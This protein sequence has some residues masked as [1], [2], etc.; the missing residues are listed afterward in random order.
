MRNI[1]LPEFGPPK[2]FADFHDIVK[3]CEEHLQILFKIRQKQDD[4]MH[5]QII[6]GQRMDIFF[7]ALINSPTRTKFP[8]CGQ[9]FTSVYTI[10]GQLVSATD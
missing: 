1:D 3:Q 10:H 9:W 5:S 2:C 4:K 6:L 7:N 8:T